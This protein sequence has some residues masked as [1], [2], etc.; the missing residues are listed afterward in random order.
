MS[1]LRF[2]APTLFLLFVLLFGL[3]ANS[4]NIQNFT[5]SLRSRLAGAKTAHD[6]M[7]LL[8][9]LSEATAV[10]VA[11]SR[12]YGDE[13]ISVAEMSR[14]RWLIAS[15]YLYNGLRYLH[16]SGLSDNL[17]QALKFTERAEQVA[18]ENGLQRI[19]VDSYCQLSKI[20]VS[21]GN[22]AQALT[23]SNE[24]M[25]MASNMDND[26]ARVRAY[27]S[28]GDA[29]LNM[30]EMLLA[31]QHFM[32]GM[33]LAESDGKDELLRDAYQ[34]MERFYASIHEYPKAVDYGMKAFELDGRLGDGIVMLLDND[35]IGELYVQ[36]KQ[37]E[38]AIR[39][40]E[41]SFRLADSL[42]MEFMKFNSYFRIF[43]MYTLSNEFSKGL[44]YIEAHRDIVN[45]LDSIGAQFFVGEIY[46]MAMVERG[47]YDSAL[48]YFRRSEPELERNA[49]PEIQCNFYIYFAHYYQL[50][51]AYPS[52][53]SYYKKAL[54]RASVMQGLEYEE[55]IGDSLKGLYGKMG[56]YKNA[57]FYETYSNDVR[58]SIRNQTSATEL[59]KVEVDND[60][61][62]RDRLAREEEQ[63]VEHRHNLQYM[64]L[65]VGLVVLF[66]GLV[67]L[68]R[69]AVPLSLIRAL[70]FLSF[71]FLFEFIILLADK[72]I[73]AWTAE[74]PWK[75]LMIKIVLGAGLVPLHHWLEHKVIHYLSG[76]RKGARADY[77][78]VS[79][80]KAETVVE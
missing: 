22:N 79:A 55:A 40:Y 11:Q 6:K 47:G 51:K 50:V 1:P 26:T 62:R 33:N 49:N 10:D 29:Y 48:Y 80:A 44:S 8:L 2:S 73:Q 70:G 27:L 65:T 43:N 72:P 74:E 77:A 60:N 34:Y 71:I 5:D 4:Q 20:S 17:A 37:N 53:I 25:A 31:L 68:G 56:D 32:A 57:L 46:G 36:S 41:R 78:K 66:V 54:D 7:D 21:R 75:V 9:Q 28:L 59:M 52:A 69:L 13:A 63:R 61:R 67:M 35:R 14:D 39:F 42:H 24:A 3:R 15:A 58:D 76:R 18:R 19:L 45:F 30:N 64:G 12:A 16:N 23:Y 38:I